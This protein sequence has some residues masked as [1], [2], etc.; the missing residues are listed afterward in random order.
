MSAPVPSEPAV[1][2]RTSG[3]SKS[4]PGSD[5]ESMI[6]SEPK[7]EPPTWS[8]EYHPGSQRVLDLHLAN[9]VTY[10]AIPYCV[11]ISPDGHRVAVGLHDGTTY[12][13]ELNTGSKIWLVSNHLNSRF[14]LT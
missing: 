8:V 14:R 3:P 2:A 6:S 12:L 13:N 7:P 9:V 10:K 5:K 1:V 4:T 11:K